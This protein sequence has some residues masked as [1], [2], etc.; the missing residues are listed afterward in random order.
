MC[1]RITR[2]DKSSILKKDT[3][4][5]PPKS[6]H[7]SQIQFQTILN[8]IPDQA[9]LKDASGR[10]LAVNNT[11]VA[12]CGLSEDKIIGHTAADV[13][14][15][16]I[17]A[18]YMRTDQRVLSSGRQW[19]FE[20]QRVRRVGKM[21]TFQTIKAPVRD[22]DD[23]IIGTTGISRDVTRYKAIQTQLLKQRERSNKLRIELQSVQDA[24]R[25]RISRELHDDLSQNLSALRLGLDWLE[26]SLPS[27]RSVLLDK[28]QKLR[29]ITDS[30]MQQMRRIALEL[31]PAILIDLGLRVAIQHVMVTTVELG[32]GALDIQLEFDVDED[33]FDQ[34]IKFV[35]FRVFQEALTNVRRHAAAKTVLVRIYETRKDL[36]LVVEDDGRGM[37]LAEAAELRPGL[38]ILGMEERARLLGGQF[39]LLSKPGEGT[40]L[41]LRVPKRRSSSH[42]K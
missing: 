39:N 1:S 13:W 14:P 16:E 35:F 26:T 41:T 10:Y 9:W 33:A 24:E 42:A 3:N 19:L 7:I 18:Q 34:D 11:Y 30:T 27:D 8:N 25:T 37:D 38:G 6:I 22:Y 17:A 28:I 31:R 29:E 40:H 23:V 15:A 2:P 20:E 32:A 5:Q 12:A 21:A 4:P 36:F